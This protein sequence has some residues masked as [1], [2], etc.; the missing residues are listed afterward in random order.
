MV[1]NV[2]KVLDLGVVVRIEWR[3]A[4]VAKVWRGCRVFNGGIWFGMG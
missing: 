3:E 2:D 4:M 1:I